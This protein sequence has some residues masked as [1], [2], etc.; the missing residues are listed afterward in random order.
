M[1]RYHAAPVPDLGD[2][3]SY[4]ILADGTPVYASGGEE[5]GRVEK[6]VSD[7][8]ADAFGGLVLDAPEGHRFVA[9]AQVERI[10]ERGVVLTI[11]AAT[12]ATLP[13]PHEPLGASAEPVLASSGLLVVPRRRPPR[14]LDPPL[15]GVGALAC[16]R[17][18]LRVL[19]CRR[20]MV[21]SPLALLLRLPAEVLGPGRVG[22]GLLAMV[23]GFTT[24]PRLL[25]SASVGATLG[26][27]G[28]GPQRDNRDDDDDD[29]DG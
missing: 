16:F 14:R 2:S 19:F 17:S 1:P 4:L 25:G 28:D 11:D 8:D 5:L 23:G 13:A 3:S 10:Y 24:E 22:V 9:A 7:G 6:I 29:R 26:R 18:G 20:G 12:A 15:G 27:K 21:L